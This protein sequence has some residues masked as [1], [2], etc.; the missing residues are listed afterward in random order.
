MEDLK[1][2]FF[3]L[4]LQLILQPTF[5]NWSFQQSK[6]QHSSASQFNKFYLQNKEKIIT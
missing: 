1:K 3:N 6:Q 2:H 4:L 5:L